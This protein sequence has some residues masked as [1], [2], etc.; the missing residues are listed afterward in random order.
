[1]HHPSRSI[2]TPSA[3]YHLLQKALLIVPTD[4][5][6]TCKGDR[7]V[8]VVCLCV[9]MYAHATFFFA[10]TCRCMDICILSLSVF[11]CSSLV[12]YSTNTSGSGVQ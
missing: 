3:D 12:R 9:C 7:R 1:M 5:E 6:E 10:R 4:W 11:M 2:E 8:N